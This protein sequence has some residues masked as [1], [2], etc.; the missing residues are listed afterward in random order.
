M[1]EFSAAEQINFCRIVS[2]VIIAT[3]NNPAFFANI[4]S[5]D[6]KAAI[7]S[8]YRKYVD[9]LIAWEIIEANESYSNDPEKPFPKSFRLAGGSA[10]VQMEEI[11]FPM[12][13]VQPLTD[14]SKLTDD[15][16]A[17]VLRNLERLTVR[18]DLLPQ[19]NLVDWVNAKQWAKKIAWGQFNLH[20]SGGVKRMFHTVI[21]M[22]RIARRNLI[23]KD[24]PTTPLY[25][26]DIKSC[27]PVL[28]LALMKND[29]ERAAYLDL[30][31]GDIYSTVGK[32][33]GI[34]ADRED[35]KDDFLEFANG[36]S[37]NYFYKFFRVRFPQLV[38]RMDKIKKVRGHKQM[39]RGCQEAEAK[40]MTQIVPRLLMAS[41]NQDKASILLNSTQRTLIC[42]GDPE[43]ILYIPMHDGWLGIEKDEH[44][45][46][47]VVRDDFL[48]R[49]GYWVTITKTPVAGGEKA[50]LLQGPPAHAV[51]RMP[52]YR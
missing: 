48:R 17:F 11:V 5:K 37:K 18:S 32:A 52:H 24:S 35:M 26:Y 13:V 33:C 46:A 40:I 10:A 39:A 45:I 2:M 34:D 41:G 23:L 14:R 7:G 20:Y 25:E 42:V 6:F 21:E 1:I 43:E 8:D 38:D 12:K 28:L 16:A 9:Q 50:T 47:T 51:E 4:R 27:H 3:K 15:V 22:P 31:A 29:A 44:K 36:R 30:L 49:V 19:A